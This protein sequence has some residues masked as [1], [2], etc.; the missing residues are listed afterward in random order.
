MLLTFIFLSYIFIL[1]YLKTLFNPQ[2][3]GF[4]CLSWDVN[5]WEEKVRSFLFG[6]V[7]VGSEASRKGDGPLCEIHKP[8]GSVKVRPEQEA[9]GPNMDPGPQCRP[10]AHQLLA[11][12]LAD[13]GLSYM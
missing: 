8:S 12:L 11:L 6:V 5:W 9:A 1:L 4:I 2:R 7:R 10:R 13:R 3:N